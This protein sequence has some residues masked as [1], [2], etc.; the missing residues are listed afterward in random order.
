MA[1]FDNN[2]WLT[3]S[4]PTPLYILRHAPSWDDSSHPS[5]KLLQELTRF[6]CMQVGVPDCGGH[7]PPPGPPPPGGPDGGGGP[8][9]LATDIFSPARQ[10]V[11]PAWTLRLLPPRVV[12]STSPCST[13]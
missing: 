11:W 9:A 4:R 7:P 12:A 1:N 6:Y 13:V 5:C 3:L 8:A 2:T 10:K